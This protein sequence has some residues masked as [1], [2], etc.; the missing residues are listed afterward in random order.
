M[1]NIVYRTART[2]FYIFDS[3]QT[4]QLS[5]FPESIARTD[6]YIPDKKEKYIPLVL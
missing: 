4:K 2:N 1:Y 3:R 6:S 5:I